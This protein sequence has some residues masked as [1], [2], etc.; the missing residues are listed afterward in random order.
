MLK[1]LILGLLL[2]IAYRLFWAKPGI[3]SPDQQDQ[4][5]QTKRQNNDTDDEYIDYEEVD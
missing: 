1:L 4:I 3:N 2:F 5:N